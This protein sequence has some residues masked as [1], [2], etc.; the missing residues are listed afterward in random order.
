[1]SKLGRTKGL[2]FER[3]IAKAFR[4]IFPKA[5]RHLEFQVQEAYGED[6]AEV[7][8]LAIQCKCF[9]RYPNP[10]IIKEITDKSKFRILALRAKGRDYEDLAVMPLEDL[11]VILNSVL[12]HE[13]DLLSNPSKKALEA[14]V[15]NIYMER[16][17]EDSDE[18]NEALE[19]HTETP[20]V[21]PDT[22][23]AS[24]ERQIDATVENEDWYN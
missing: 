2:N 4:Y 8:N 22:I 19:A 3:Y 12:K 9:Q 11:M 16:K 20:I 21:N 10:S 1:M 18:S 15:W 24:W 7:G 5:R 23:M 13:P 6:L 17:A 14:S